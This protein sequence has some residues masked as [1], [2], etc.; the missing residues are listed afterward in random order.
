[1][2][3][4]VA[5]EES[6]R[7]CTEFRKLGH[8]AYSC[9]IE[10]CSGGHPEWHIQDDVLPLLNGNCDFKTVNGDMHHL[11]GKWDMI[12]AFPPCTHLAV[13]GSRH[14]EE[15]RLDGRQ[16]E[17]IEFF[18]KFFEAD[19][20]KIVIENPVNIIS[21]DYVTKWFPDIV[22]KYDL[23]RKPTQRIHP[24]MFGDNFSKC[25]CL[26]EKGVEPLVPLIKEEPEME[27]HEWVDKKTGKKKRQNLW[28]YQALRNTKT[29]ED[30]RRV[31]SKTFP[32]IAKAMAE[33]WG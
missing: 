30:R 33:Q 6:Q 17:G 24:W 12:I 28:M 27:Y 16:I 11:I 18:C 1:M 21:G 20:N 8:E 26:W 25:T 22:E 10:P 32:G 31:R 15:K 3:V 2:K 14:F 13:S 5:C 4:L 19:C 7:V 29:A 9:D 23:P